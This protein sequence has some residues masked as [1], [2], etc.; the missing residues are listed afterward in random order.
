[1]IMCQCIVLG[2]L[3]VVA[4][5]VTLSFGF[6]VSHERSGPGYMRVH[7]IDFAVHTS[8][9]AT[10]HQ[11]T[12]CKYGGEQIIHGPGHVMPVQSHNRPIPTRT[13]FLSHTTP[14]SATYFAMTTTSQHSYVIYQT[15]AKGMLYTYWHS[16]KVLAFVYIDITCIVVREAAQQQLKRTFRFVSAGSVD[17]VVCTVDLM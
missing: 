11:P 1:M 8:W 5:L 10:H 7:M 17:T 14:R 3:V 4:A 16:F 13:G 2:F 9:S 15:K 6:I 12:S